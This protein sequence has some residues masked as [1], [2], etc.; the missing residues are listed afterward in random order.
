M[1]RTIYLDMDGV[2]ADFNLYVSNIVGREIGWGVSDL[3]DEEW[4][5]ISKNEN[6]YYQL[7]LIKESTKLVAAAKSFIPSFNVEFLTAIPRKS[8]MPSAQTDKIQWVE[9]YYPGIKVNFG[10][11]SQDKQHWC[12]PLDILIDDKPENVEEWYAAGGIAIKHVDNFD[13]TIKNLVLATQKAEPA[14]LT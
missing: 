6:L 2:V 7:P 9:K 4:L 5:F 1:T 8:S 12:R 11:Y 13:Q 3:S 10:P 14:I